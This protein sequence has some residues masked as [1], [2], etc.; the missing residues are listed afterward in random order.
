MSTERR[1][2]FY[3]LTILSDPTGQA[4]VAMH[5]TKS[6]TFFGEEQLTPWAPDSPTDLPLPLSEEIL[7]EI[8]AVLIENIAA[9]QADHTA[10]IASIN[11]AHA[12]QVTALEEQL[13][14]ALAVPATEAA[15][16]VLADLDESFEALPE[17]VQVI[18]EPAWATVRG[19]MQAGKSARAYRFVQA[20]NV[21]AQL[22]EVRAS[23]LAKIAE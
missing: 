9:L 18:F 8:N 6:A 19:L 23:I 20:L 14:A 16:T 13:A 4:A 22:E 3:R 17:E 5:E 11:E 1:T 12:A 10:A 2:L 7:G 21:P 15:S